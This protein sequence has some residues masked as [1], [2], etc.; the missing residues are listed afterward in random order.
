MSLIRTSTFRTTSRWVLA[1]C[2]HDTRDLPDDV[3]A[4]RRD[5]LASDLHEQAIW[6]W[7]FIRPTLD[8]G[9]IESPRNR[10]SVA[11]GTGTRRA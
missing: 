9:D 6:W 5:E 11:H 10:S 7:P 2:A 8:T 1:W 3:A 4:A